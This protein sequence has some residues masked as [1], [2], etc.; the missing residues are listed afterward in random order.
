[1]HNVRGWRQNSGHGGLRG[2]VLSRTQKNPEAW[3]QHREETALAS[4]KQANDKLTQFVQITIV[5][6][7]KL[8]FFGLKAVY[9]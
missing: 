5:K 1:M 6:T 9:N 2:L 8:Y 7:K 4:K 3:R